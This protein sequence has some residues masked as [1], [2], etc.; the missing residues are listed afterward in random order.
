MAGGSNV[1]NRGYVGLTMLPDIHF[2][3][4]GQ[5]RTAK[6]ERLKFRLSVRRTW[7]FGQQEIG[8]DKTR[9][10][11]THNKEESPKS[12]LPFNSCTALPLASPA[13]LDSL[14]LLLLSPRAAMTFPNALNLLSMMF[15]IFLSPSLSPAVGMS[16]NECCCN[17]AAR[18]S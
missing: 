8:R 14:S 6:K 9:E 17:C 18:V 3:A 10:G 1:T 4:T 5:L 2:T 15:C 16:V 12:D 7:T 13:P 11:K